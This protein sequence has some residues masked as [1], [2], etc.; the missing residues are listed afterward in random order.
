MPT[1]TR[2]RRSSRPTS[3]RVT[4]RSQRAKPR[5]DQEAIDDQ[6]FQQKLDAKRFTDGIVREAN[7]QLQCPDCGRSTWRMKPIYYVNWVANE[8]VATMVCRKCKRS[9]L[10]GTHI[11]KDPEEED[12]E[13]SD[14]LPFGIF[15]FRPRPRRRRKLDLD[16]FLRFQRFL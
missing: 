16:Q 6:K 2:T 12:E 11:E 14:D 5:L 10:H 1:K 8:L 7:E 3:Q 9:I 13:E 4:P 15:G